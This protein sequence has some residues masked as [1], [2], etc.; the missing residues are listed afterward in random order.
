VIYFCLLLLMGVISE[1][2]SAAINFCSRQPGPS[3]TGF[4]L[5]LKLMAG[6]CILPNTFQ[7]NDTDA[8]TGKGIVQRGCPLHGIVA[9]RLL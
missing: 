7:S 2:P 1:K 4:Y 5:V 3:R 6:H 9:A 8:E